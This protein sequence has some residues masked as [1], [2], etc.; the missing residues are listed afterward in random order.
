MSDQFDPILIPEELE[1]LNKYHN[2]SGIELL[3]ETTHIAYERMPVFDVVME[4]L[5]SLLSN[6]LRGLVADVSEASLEKTSY[7][8]FGEFIQSI[9]IPALINVFEIVPW[10]KFGLL[11]I[12]NDLV[13]ALVETLLGGRKS[14]LSSR[15][16]T[17]SYT[18]IEQNIAD[19]LTKIMLSD[20][21]QAFMPVTT[22][23]FNH[24]RTELN[25][26]FAG[27]VMNN[28]ACIVNKIK[29]AIGERSGYV[30]LVFPLSSLEP[31]REKLLQNFMGEK[32]GQDSIWENHLA[33]E[34]W[35]THLQAEAVLENITAPLSDVLKW[36]VGSHMELTADEDSCVELRCGNQTIITGKIGSIKGKTAIQIEEN[37]LIKKDKE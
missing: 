33:N 27:I 16:N 5:M 4:R 23:E 12:Q 20:L 7:V 22:V 6:S 1:M 13:I 14:Q 25:P 21:A 29:I 15:N 19:K 36:T 11:T 26:K 28:N 10:K 3:I 18:G 32:F 8:R 17:R 24:S 37:L 35:Y 9:Q 30:E 34:V 2:K 31:V